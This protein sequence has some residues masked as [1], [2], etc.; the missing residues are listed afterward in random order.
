M[1][2]HNLAYIERQLR[3]GKTPEEL[4]GK[5]IGRGV[6][7]AAYLF[8]D[9]F[10]VKANAQG[11]F[12]ATPQKNPPKWIKAFGA[13][14]P[15]TYKAGSYIIQEYVTVLETLIDKDPKFKDT[16]VYK[17]WIEM[18]RHGHANGLAGSDVHEKNCGV[19][20]DGTLVVFD[21]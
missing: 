20:K 2:A 14:G 10:V 21:W 15:R 13:R 1:A 11:G 6:C 17:Q 12:A 8:N 18:Y 7:K 5:E 3:L 4:G 19:C 9:S 16:P